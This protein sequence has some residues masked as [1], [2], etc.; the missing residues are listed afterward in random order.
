VEADSSRMLSRCL[1]LSLISMVFSLAACG[2]DAETEAEAFATHTAELGASCTL[3]RPVIWGGPACVESASTPLTLADG[4]SY[5][6]SAAYSP[7]GA[8]WGAYGVTCHNGSLSTDFEYCYWG[9]EP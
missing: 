3:Y 6:A 9:H 7:Y 4:E 1:K 5:S 8:V 2:G